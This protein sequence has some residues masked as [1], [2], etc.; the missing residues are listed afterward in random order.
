M[1]VLLLADANSPHTIKWVNSLTKKCIDVLLF[2]I[3]KV[4]INDYEKSENVKFFSLNQVIDRKE[5][6]ILKIV[7]LRALPFI[8]KV[9]DQEKP[10]ILH[11]HYA[12]SYGL[13]GALSGFHPFIISVWGGDVLTFPKR[14]IIH[15][16]ILE[17]NLKKADKI[18]STSYALA[19][20]TKLYTN[21][22]VE[23]IPFGVDTEL[24]KPL[25][26]ES[27]FDENDIVIGT[28]KT[29]EKIYGIEYLIKAFKML[30]ERYPSLPL[31][32]LIVGGGSLESE[33]KNLCKNFGIYDKVIFTGKVSYSDVI[34]YHNIIAIFV[35][36][37]EVESFGVS[38]VEA[39][40]CG[41]PVVVSN[42]GGLP[43]VV[44]NG[45]TGFVVSPKNPHEAANAI[46]KLI[47][48]EDLRKSMGE[49]GRKRVIDLY[50]WNKSVEKTIMI[51]KTFKN[52]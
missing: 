20:E 14:S 12:S 16:F 48:N 23:V 21:K 10:D 44:E 45:V 36:L 4:V 24:F 51:Y 47:F 22:N 15:R 2:S 31:K 52:K 40:A 49:E 43:E 3:G 9:I 32:L 41:K 50:D 25:K 8:R 28:I 19:K 11:A 39:S 7:Y 35:A 42:V 34:K 13:L 27:I 37:S 26:V 18:F 6:S 17:Y 29:L 1:K 38:V 30:N 5:G 33:L 46:E